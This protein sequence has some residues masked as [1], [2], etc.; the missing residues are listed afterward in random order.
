MNR[1]RCIRG[2]LLGVPLVVVLV[3]LQSYA[4][5]PTYDA[6]LEASPARARTLV[7]GSIADASLLNPALNADVASSRLAGLIFEGLLERDEDQRLVGRLARHFELTEE[8][9][10]AVPAGAR[11][12]DGRPVDAA[13]LAALIEARRAQDAELAAV[14]VDVA[15]QAARVERRSLTLDGDETPVPVAVRVPPRVTLRLNTVVPQLEALLAPLLGADHASDWAR[16]EV[17]LAGVEDAAP[18]TPARAAALRTALD[19]QLEAWLPVIEHNPV[20]TFELRRDV[21]FH[22]GH[23]FDADDVRFTYE[24]IMAPRNRSPRGSDFEPIKALEVPDAHTVRVV[25]KR[26]FSPAINAWTMGI[27]P[28]HLLNDER[29]AAEAAER[30]LDETAR[31]SFGLREMR[32]NR[33][34]VGTG[35]F[36]FERWDSDEV[37]HLRANTAHWRGAPEL[38]DYYFRVMPD[39]LAQELEF[40]AGA[41]DI[42]APQPH[43][44]ARYRD[45]ARYRA[46][47]TPSLG[48]TYIGYNNARPPL[49]DARVRRALGMAIDVDA[50][51]RYVQYGEADRVTGPYPL[52]TPWYDPE[53]AP[54]PHDPQAAA[55]L[56]GE[57]GWSRGSDGWLYRDGQRF[58]INLISNNGNPVRRAVLAIAQASWQR[59]GVKTNTQ[60]FEWAVFL[61]DFVNPAEY[62]A[63][64]LGWVMGMDHDLFQLWHSSQVGFAKLNFVAYRSAEADRLMEQIRQEYRH[65]RLVELTRALHRRIAAD[66]PY[67][68]LFAPRGTRVL[69]RKLVMRG[70]DGELTA[71][72]PSRGGDLFYYMD[73]WLKHAGPTLAPGGG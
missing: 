73:R 55:A 33:A 31:A 15:V 42:Y 43:Q 45:D 67:T 5:V 64:V 65:E 20:I 8:A 54:L 61:E 58:E 56:L 40:R 46:F 49:D 62:D 32:F 29:V 17:L 34:P 28:E 18:A 66:Q 11:L 52:G 30:G 47:S 59:I 35:Q 3:L 21:A 2:A 9:H 57:L 24:A 10:L 53:L 71:L 16:L 19:E 48:Y 44:V 6:Q 36:R 41:L 63:V 22:D 68:F 27:L 14:L 13:T 4:W 26:L 50:I 60:L 70:A 39:L 69:D 23:P 7:E 51:V 12:A 38:G 37:V 1:G 25:Y 72:R